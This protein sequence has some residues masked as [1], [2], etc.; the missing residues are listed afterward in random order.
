MAAISPGAMRLRDLYAQAPK[1]AAKL[2]GEALERNA[3]NIS[4]TSRELGV[5]LPTL[6]RYVFDTECAGP[7]EEA[8]ARFIAQHA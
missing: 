1:S 3:W 6:R 4:A 8:R 5:P 2:I 7:L